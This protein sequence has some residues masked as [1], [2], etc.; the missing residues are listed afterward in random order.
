MV[1]MS[2]GRVMENG[3]WP[4]GKRLVH[5]VMQAEMES[6]AKVKSNAALGK[7][8]HCKNRAHTY[9]SPDASLAGACGKSVI[10]GRDS[11]NNST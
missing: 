1:T 2:G 6:A 9:R 3:V 8:P 4:N 7:R 5:Q 10:C 11:H